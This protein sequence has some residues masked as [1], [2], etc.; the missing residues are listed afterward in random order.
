MAL[1]GYDSFEAVKSRLDEI[2]DAV[3][4]D[5]LPLDD[6]LA[7]Y[8]EAVALGLRASDLLEEGIEAR[9]EAE[10]ASADAGA[11][12]PGDAVADG[13][14]AAGD[15]AD[16]ASDGPDPGPILKGA[17]MNERILDMVSSPADLKVL[18]NE[19]LSI[20]AQEIR[21]EIITVASETGG[22]VASSLG[23][24]EIILAAHSMLDCPHDKLVFDVGHQA[25]A[26]KLVTGRLDEFKTL[27]SYGGLSGFTKPDE[28][29]LRRA[30]V[31]PRVR[32]AVRGARLGA[33]ARAV[34]RRREDRG[35]HRRCGAVRRHGVRGAQPHGP[36]ADPHGHHPQRQRDVHL[37]QRRGAYEA[38]RL[39]ARLH[40]VPRDARLRAGE[41]G[42]ERPLRHR[43]C[44][45]RPQHERIAQA[46]HH[47][48]LDDLRAAGHP[49]HRAHRRARHRASQ[50]DACGRARHGRPRAPSTW[51]RARAPDTR[52]R[53]PIRRSSTASR[54]FTSPPAR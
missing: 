26:H 25:Y 12:A 34:R 43:A 19:E 47:P 28:E 11:G 37:A 17:S 2:V 41:D 16:P 46:V 49:L 20:L 3:G 1:E 6:A 38:P 15:A 42:E 24:V 44:Q 27:R 33:G 9:Q 23:A 10:R 14:Q 7:L 40:A 18:T 31:R 5:D 50:G 29:P 48:A 32:L 39:H 52:P 36:D 22:H 45:L 8:E 54:R 13:V 35:R 4:D 51:S 21:E 53:W 30:P